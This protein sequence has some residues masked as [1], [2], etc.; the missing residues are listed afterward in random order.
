[1]SNTASVTTLST[2]RQRNMIERAV[3]LKTLI[4][5]AKDELDEILAV[6]KDIGDGDFAGRDG[7]KIQV[8]TS[9]RKSL[10][11][12]VVKGFLTPAQIL[13]A[14]RSTITVTAKVL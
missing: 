3:E 13:A 1:M 8:R 7:H 10:D 6:F 2:L 4:E 12:A 5:G 14:T 9:E 11:T